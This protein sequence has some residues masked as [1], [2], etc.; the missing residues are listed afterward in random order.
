M[1]NINENGHI[2]STTPY[3]VTDVA[4]QKILEVFQL[5]NPVSFAQIAP[6]AQALLDKNETAASS[7]A[8]MLIFQREIDPEHDLVIVDSLAN[9]ADR[10]NLFKLLS[11][12]A[13]NEQI[14]GL[15]SDTEI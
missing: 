12:M 14:N 4:V 15:L 10:G 3:E 5:P 11:I 7:L 6:I 8:A 13:Q 2:Y 9:F 1:S